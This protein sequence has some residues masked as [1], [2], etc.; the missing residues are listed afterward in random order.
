MAGDI[1]TLINVYLNGEISS[2]FIW[3]VII[4]FV[5]C[6][7]VFKYFFFSVYESVR[8]TKLVK[9]TVPCFGVALVIAS[10]IGGF[11]IV[12]SPAQQRA[13]RFDQQ[14]VNDLQNIQ[15]QVINY[16]QKK[17]VLPTSIVDLNDPLANFTVPADPETAAAYQYLMKGKLAFELCATFGTDSQTIGA[18]RGNVSGIVYPV[19]PIP[20][21]VA[22]N[23]N[24]ANGQACFDRTIDPAMYPPVSPVK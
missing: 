1:I 14:R 17:Q 22:D 7:A 20:T 16:W 11:L 3:K 9:K 13:V 18:V 23:W 19:A 2:R 15:W 10:I 8:W 21:G 4:L 5:I 24:H 12:G 6:S